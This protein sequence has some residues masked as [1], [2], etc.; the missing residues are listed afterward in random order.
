MVD[1]QLRIFS[2]LANPLGEVGGRSTC[3]YGSRF[4]K[5]RSAGVLVL[6][7]LRPPARAAFSLPGGVASQAGGRDPGQD[8]TGAGG[9]GRAPVT[10]GAATGTAARARRE[11]GQ[12]AATRA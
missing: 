9:R 5:L 2:H 7:R 11:P 4:R 1:M 12:V 3:I 6:S 8:C 10:A